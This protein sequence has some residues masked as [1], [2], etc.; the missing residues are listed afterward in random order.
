MA[1]RIEKAEGRKHGKR[2]GQNDLPKNTDVGAAVHGSGFFQLLRDG[3]EEVFHDHHV[4]RADRAGQKH[5]K[6]GIFH[7]QHI[8]NDDVAGDHAAAEEHGEDDHVEDE[9]SA[10]KAGLGDGVGHGDGEEEIDEC[11]GYSN[12]DGIF[13]AG[14]DF[15]G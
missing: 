3:L 9:V 11:S 12:E 10:A 6:I 14:N 7:V 2:Q 8:G 4:I 15:V 13:E 5:G 1:D